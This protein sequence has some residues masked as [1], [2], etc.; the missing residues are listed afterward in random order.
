[1]QH[2][3][4]VHGQAINKCR[5]KDKNL[6]K[7]GDNC[8]YSHQDNEVLNVTNKQDFQDGQVT[9]PPEIKLMIT[10]MMEKAIEIW[11][12]K[13]SRESN[14]SQLWRPSSNSA[15]FVEGNQLGAELRNEAAL[16]IQRL[17]WNLVKRN[18]S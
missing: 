14:R 5:Y 15:I 3:K 7:F 18:F 13:G 6:C 11:Q 4:E 10:T 17:V 9:L 2:R 12:E 1:M 16:I 8:W